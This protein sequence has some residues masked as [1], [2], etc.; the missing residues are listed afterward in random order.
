M[1]LAMAGALAL[2]LSTA[3]SAQPETPGLSPSDSTAVAA[4][5]AASDSATYAAARREA[6]H[7][8]DRF[9][10]GVAS[11]DGYFDWLGTVAYRRL[12]AVDP[13]FEH[14]IHFELGA[15]HKDYLTE[16]AASAYWF[17]RPRRILHGRGPIRPILEGGLGLHLAVQFADIVGFGDWASHARAFA[18][19]H[20]VA[21]VEADLGDRWGVALRGRLTVPSHHPLDFA[22]LV[23]FLR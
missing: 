10:L 18:K 21:G 8:P 1:A 11:P 12:V 4:A 17:A 23:L 3:V 7:D 6:F 5:M 2:I 15:A 19:A 13:R 14:T 20:G 22:Q 9:E 16:G